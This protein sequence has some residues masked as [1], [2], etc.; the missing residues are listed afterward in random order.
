MP[1]GRL[2]SSHA[3]RPARALVLLATAAVAVAVFANTLPNALLYDDPGALAMAD[4]GVRELAV[5]RYGLTYLSIR[6]DRLFWDTWPPG[7]HLTN[8][9][10]QG[11]AAALA[12]ACALVLT[13]RLLVAVVAGLLFAVHP[14]H[15]EA[16]ASIENR[17]ELLAWILVA[18]SLLLYRVRPRRPWT[19]VAAATAFVLAMSAKDAA[20]VG[21]AVMLPLSDVVPLAPAARRDSVVPALAFFLV[22][23]SA[24]I[25][26]AG[27]ATSVWYAGPVVSRFTPAAIADVTEGA[28]HGYADVLRTSLAAV[29]EVARL[30]LFPVQLSVDHP[31]RHPT[32]LG[33]GAVLLGLALLLGWIGTAVALVRRAP[34]AAFAMAWVVVM[35][36]P[37]SNVVPLTPYFVAERYLYVPSFGVCL[38]LAIGAEALH[39]RA[40]AAGRALA[41]GIVV[42]LVGWGSWRSAARNRDWRD[43]LSLWTA[44][45]ERAPAASA[46]AHK[47]IGRALWAA[48]RND[49]AIAHLHKA[50]ALGPDT[51]DTRS[52]LGLALLG[53]GRAQEAV[54]EFDRALALWPSN[55]LVRYDLA[56]ALLRVGRREDAMEH[57]RRLAGADAWRDLPRGVRA[58]LAARGMS[59][60]E[61]RTRVRDWIDRQAP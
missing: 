1:A 51:G 13:R 4:A 41:I 47:E 17:K 18:S 61:F 39:R 30:L 3:G 11:A 53:A 22:G 24:A 45:V 44:A 10:L 56:W 60:E 59:P 46:R 21:A 57:L 15:V 7:L 33:D 48:G 55:P 2:R 20:A 54:A 14:V 5:Q 49:E 37:L 9:L 25:W 26:Y 42:L 12:A 34:A 40:G 29:P 19:L 52:N 23:A 38:L 43:D 6:L 50:L 58:A 32:G 27:T 8:V 36:L 35:Y 16:V 28:C 31:V